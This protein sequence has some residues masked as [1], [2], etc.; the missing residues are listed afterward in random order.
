[1]T[2]A[3]TKWLGLLTFITGIIGI[4]LAGYRNATNEFHAW[5][6]YTDVVQ[7]L[8]AEYTYFTLWAVFMGTWFGWAMF[9][10]T[11]NRNTRMMKALRIDAAAMCGVTAIVYNFVYE[12]PWVDTLLAHI[13]IWDINTITP[14]LTVFLWILSMR[15][16]YQP[17]ITFDTVRLSLVIP[18][19]WVA[20]AF[21]KG[22]ISG[23]YFPYPFMNPHVVG[24]AQ[25]IFNVLGI[26]AG[27]LA[28]VA[29]LSLVEKVLMPKTT[30]ADA[31][32]YLD[33]FALTKRHT[34][35]WWSA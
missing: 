32:D 28:T 25:A 9:S 16:R 17:D 2:T 10:G 1:M 18:S 5:P 12:D 22:Y 13:V 26:Y 20:Y 34:Q 21:I 11:G 31:K 15:E 6:A 4:V 29:L 3:L 23:G 7:K 14:L 24:L 35:R 33:E 27:L 30:A 19:V 8:T